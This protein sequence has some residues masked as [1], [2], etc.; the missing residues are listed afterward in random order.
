[1]STSNASVTVDTT[2]DRLDTAG[3][4]SKFS[5]KNAGAVTVYLGDANVTTGNG[6]PL[7]PGEAWAADLGTGDEVYG[8]TASSTAEVRVFEVGV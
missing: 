2:A 8:R 7:E 4:A 5:C 1:M 6:Y 3:K